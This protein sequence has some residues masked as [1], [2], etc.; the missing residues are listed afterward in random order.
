MFQV[1]NG[2]GESD[3]MV[4]TRRDT[5]HM[6]KWTKHC[7]DMKGRSRCHVQAEM[8]DYSARAIFLLSL[9]RL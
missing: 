9:S 1:M 4:P 2:G 3:D 6:T 5:F 7:V 8:H